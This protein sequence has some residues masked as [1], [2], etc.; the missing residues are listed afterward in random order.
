[1]RVSELTGVELDYWTARA[2]GYMGIKIKGPGQRVAGQFR[3]KQT[4][5]VKSEGT[6]SWREFNSQLW[7]TAGPIIERELI[8]IEA[9]HPGCWFA[10][11][12]YTKHSGRAE[13]PL[14]AAMRAFVA[15]KFGDEVPA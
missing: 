13:T 12:R 4:V 11:E 6:D 5:L 14:I 9:E 1:M 15:S 8:S 3:T 2:E 10:Q 7:T